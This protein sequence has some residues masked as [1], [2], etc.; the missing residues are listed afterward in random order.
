M[1]ARTRPGLSSNSKHKL[2]PNR[3][4]CAQCSAVCMRSLSPLMQNFWVL[5]VF[6]VFDVLALEHMDGLRIDRRL[7]DTDH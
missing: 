7:D 2:Q 1:I 5:G 6:P 3:I 4:L